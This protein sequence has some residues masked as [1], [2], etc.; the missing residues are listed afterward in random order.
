MFIRTHQ[1]VDSPAIK[2]F[3]RRI[4]LNFLI[5][6]NLEMSFESLVRTGAVRVKVHEQPVSQFCSK[7]VG[8]PLAADCNKFI[9]FHFI[10]IVVNLKWIVTI[11]QRITKRNPTDRHVIV[12]HFSVKWI[13]VDGYSGGIRLQI[14]VTFDVVRVMIREVWSVEV[15][16]T[17]EYLIALFK[18]LKKKFKLN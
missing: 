16:R 17:V 4:K 12:G 13:K 15:A 6:L 7:V 18:I 10:R 3:I 8:S 11:Y 1:S 14:P 5:E 9:N 2:N